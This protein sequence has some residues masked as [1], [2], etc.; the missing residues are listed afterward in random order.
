MQA[1]VPSLKIV[2]QNLAGGPKQKKGLVTE[3]CLRAWNLPRGVPYTRQ[4]Y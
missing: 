1:V 3:I 2:L 4:N